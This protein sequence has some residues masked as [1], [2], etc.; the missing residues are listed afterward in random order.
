[1]GK[2]KHG[3]LRHAAALTTHLH[4]DAIE[5]DDKPDRFEPPLTLNHGVQPRR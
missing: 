4:D 5:V 1:M 2:Y 3:V